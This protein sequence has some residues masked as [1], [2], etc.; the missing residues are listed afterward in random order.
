MFLEACLGL[1]IDAPSNRISVS[2]PRLPESIS[3]FWVRRLQV[4]ST[5]VDLHFERTEDRVRAEILEKRGGEVDIQFS[6]D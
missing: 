5:T 4:G 1:S 3:H 2:D 6:T